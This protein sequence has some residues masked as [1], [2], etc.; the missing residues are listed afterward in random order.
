MQITIHTINL[1]QILQ[2]GSIIAWLLMGLIA[3]FLATTFVR[4]RGFGCL[5]DTI[6]GLIGAFIGGIL[7]NALELGHFAFCGSVFISFIGAVIFVALIQIF[8]GERG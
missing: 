8:T 6:V 3:G 2:P 4:G 5:G 1:G 7:A